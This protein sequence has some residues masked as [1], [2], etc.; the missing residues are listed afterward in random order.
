MG[1]GGADGVAERAIEA[2]A[3]FAASHDRHVGEV[4]CIEGCADRAHPAVI[5]SEA[6]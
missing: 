4:G 5:M 3:Y 1:L 6:R 2:D